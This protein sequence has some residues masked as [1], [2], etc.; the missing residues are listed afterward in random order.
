MSLKDY[1]RK[2]SF[3][4]TPEPKGATP[5]DA[6]NQWRFCVQ[7][8][9]ASR[10]HY[11]LRLELDGVL[12]SWAVPK[13]PSLDWAEK[14]LSIH[15]EDHPIEYLEF[16]GVIPQ[17]EYG[18]GTV[19]VWDLGTW[20]PRHGADKA[21]SDY[22]SGA[23]K[24]DLHGEKLQGGWMLKRLDHRGENQWLLIKEKDTAMRELADFDV[25]EEL[26]SSVLTGR[27][28]DEIAAD[29]SVVWNSEPKV[30]VEF[31]PGDFPKAKQSP[32]LGIIRPSLP[33]AT[34]IAPSGEKWIH[35]IKYDGY[36]M[37]AFVEQGKTK[38][39]SRNGKDW[40]DKLRTL[41]HV[42]AQLPCDS[43]IV[44]GEV[45]MMNQDGVTSFQALQNRIGAGK[46]SELRYYVFDVLYLNGY[47]LTGMPMS[48]RKQVLTRL[49]EANGPSDRIILSEHLVGD[50]PTIFRQA[51]KL[52]VE[53]IVS[54][55]IDKRY[56]QGRFEFWLKTKC[57]QSREF[58]IGGFTPPTASRK[59][60]GAI[61]L[62]TPTEDESGKA[63]LHF[64]G[65]VGTGFTHET[66]VHLRSLL[67]A[68]KIPK[69]PFQNLNRRTADKGTIW[70]EPKLVAEIEFAGWTGDGVF[71]FGSFKGLRDDINIADLETTLPVV[72]AVEPANDPLN[73]VVHPD[74]SPIDAPPSAVGDVRPAPQLELPADLAQVKISS[75]D[76]V[77]YP[78]M[79]ITKLGVATYYAQV[80]PWMLP[81]V[82]GRPVS[83]LRCPGGVG[84]TCF[85]QKR[86]PKGLHES[87]ERVELPTTEGSRMFLVV[88]DL[89]GL[90]AL[91]QFGVLEFHVS[92]AR[93]DKFDRPDRLVID[94]DPDEKLPFAQTATAAIE[95]RDWLDEAG[96]RSFLKTTGG[97]GLHIVVPIRR[98]HEWEETKRFGRQLAARFEGRF[99]KR[100]TTN[101][102]K[103]ARKGK[104]L[105]DSMRN[106]RGAT[107]VAAFSTRAKRRAS[108]SVPIAWNELEFLASSASM[109]LQAVLGRLAQMDSD[110]WAEI[111]EVEQSITKQVWKR[112]KQD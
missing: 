46:D 60:L 52:G 6:E 69:S 81:H 11:D 102:S 95:I 10:L 100:F 111:D 4:N 28:L 54:K 75:P 93:V 65:K 42:V 74:E 70:V 109:S 56:A 17:N 103:S 33:T 94:L 84:Q 51:C 44:D 89:V 85:F 90:L 14:R 25:L 105:F 3:G 19:M 107:S 64:T 38:F 22:Q 50:G 97:K 96:L 48:E 76:R 98:R 77:V 16:E 92:N 106:T 13:G 67:D 57:L 39:Q 80:G 9:D 37:L 110:P 101:P 30:P 34:R 108:V 31:D 32:M 86:A 99:P 58:L 91:V 53:G 79:G 61:L 23:L 55:R 43:A 112:L 40:T 27:D 45:V 66:L 62:G 5:A 88:H 8:H 73:N 78:D 59:G 26:P 35:E 29:K 7:K 71:R 63:T 2:R 18:G 36:R 47:R 12:L 87:V 21:A 24:F 15:V 49:V 104:I 68:T 82:I 41:G 20:T 72:E 83:L 1:H